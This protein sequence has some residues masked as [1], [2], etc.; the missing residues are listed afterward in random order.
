MTKTTTTELVEDEV[1]VYE[2]EECH[3][4]VGEDEIVTDVQ[5]DGDHVETLEAGKPVDVEYGEAAVRHLCED[6]SGLPH[7]V[8]IEPSTTLESAK[9]HVKGAFA[10]AAIAAVFLVFA[11]GATYDGQPFAGAVFV[12]LAFIATLWAAIDAKSTRSRLDD[13]AE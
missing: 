6:C 2:C 8:R 13:L 3:V 5:L 10:F 9:A 11:A 1:V 12:G 7:A 4:Y